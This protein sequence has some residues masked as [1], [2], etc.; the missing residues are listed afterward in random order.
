M[1]DGISYFQT[2]NPYPNLLTEAIVGGPDAKDQFPDDRMNAPQSEPTTYI[3]APF[4]G[5][6]AYF[7]AFPKV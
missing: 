2:K 5:I 6:L 4:V 1:Q 7:K 3:N